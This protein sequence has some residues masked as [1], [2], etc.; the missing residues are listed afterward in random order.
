[1]VEGPGPF[2]GRP[3]AVRPEGP[4]LRL[5]IHTLD[6]RTFESNLE[7]KYTDY[8]KKELQASGAAKIVQDEREADF[9]L[10]GA[11]ESV[12]LPSLTFT[13]DQTRESRVT[14][15]VKVQVKDRETGTIRWTQTLQSSADFFVGAA[16]QGGG[17][18]SGLQFNRVL[19]DRALEQ[20]GQLIAEDLSD[21]LLLAREQGVFSS[22]APGPAARAS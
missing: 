19:Q 22:S 12:S 5:A 15:S 21:R 7:L 16:P 6:N 4:P 13:P 1:M 14:V 10:T 18:A 17:A 3:A 9:I 2:L 20:A 11:I 8:L